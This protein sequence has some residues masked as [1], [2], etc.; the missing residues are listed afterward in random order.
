MGINP[1]DDFEQC[2]SGFIANMVHSCGHISKMWYAAEEFAL[3][4][5]QNQRE[6]LCWNCEVRNFMHSRL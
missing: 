1:E 3:L 4:D 5:K 2:T 6:K